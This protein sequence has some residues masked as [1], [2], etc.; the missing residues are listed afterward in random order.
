MSWFG[1][2]IEPNIQQQTQEWRSVLSLRFPTLQSPKAYLTHDQEEHDEN[3]F[4]PTFNEGYKLG[5]KKARNSAAGLI[6]ILILSS[7][8]FLTRSL[9]L[10]DCRRVCQA[11]CR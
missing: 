2:A 7:I 5:E 6:D 3:D 10:T 1:P 11:R 9:L 8:Y 4:K